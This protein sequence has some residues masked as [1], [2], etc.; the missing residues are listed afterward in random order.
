MDMMVGRPAVTGIDI[1]AGTYPAE[2]T[3]I[4]AFTGSAWE[5]NDPV[6]QLCFVWDLGEDEAGND[7]RIFDNFINMKR[8]PTGVPM[9][10]GKLSRFYDRVSALYGERFDP[11]AADLEWGIALSDPYNSPQGIDKIPRY[12]DGDRELPFDR[13]PHVVSLQV[14]GR[15]LLGREANILVEAKE[16]NDGRERMIIS[17]A[18]PPPRSIG[19]RR[20]V[21]KQEGELPVD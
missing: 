6:F 5:S 11:S 9:M 21:Q 8:D 14:K 12:S 13:R 20:Q 1:K 16:G 18:V 19:A 3:N 15:E 7:V 2:C 17:S 10:Q 4:L